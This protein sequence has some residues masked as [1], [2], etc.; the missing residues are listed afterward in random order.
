MDGYIG[1]GVFFVI[2]LIF[3]FLALIPA[4]L[5]QP[6]QP[7]PEKLIPY[8]CGVDTIGKNNVQFHI[9]Y[10]MYALVFLLFDIETVFLYPWAVKY[11]ELGLFA[12]VE[13]F[14]FVSILA[15]GLWYA[16]KKGALTWK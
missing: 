15:V 3:P 12:L 6:R 14:V 13:M 9:G 5:L 10:F 11:G 1:I 4:R 16:W 2:T 8:E 7:T